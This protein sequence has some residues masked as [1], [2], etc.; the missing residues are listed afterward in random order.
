MYR[1]Q[2]RKERDKRAASLSLSVGKRCGPLQGR[3]SLPSSVGEMLEKGWGPGHLSRGVRAGAGLEEGRDSAR[4]GGGTDPRW[5][6]ANA[7]KWDN[8]RCV[9]GDNI[10][11]GVEL[12]S[13]RA[14][15]AEVQEVGCGLLGESHAQDDLEKTRLRSE[16]QEALRPS[17]DLLASRSFAAEA[18]GLC[19]GTV[20]DTRVQHPRVVLS[21]V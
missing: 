5:K 1:C 8:I 14:V 13:S 9:K 16:Y 19:D 20:W 10:R 11:R 18:R 7:W 3:P 6:A 4:P 21:E 2:Q 12:S 15:R 17:S